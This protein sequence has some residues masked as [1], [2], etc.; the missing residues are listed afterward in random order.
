MS[1][2]QFGQTQQ[3]ANADAG[4]DLLRQ[5]AAR[6]RIEHPARHG[7]LKSLRQVHDID[8]VE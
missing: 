6:H 7:E 4:F 5:L 2:Q 8:F 3:S 1:L